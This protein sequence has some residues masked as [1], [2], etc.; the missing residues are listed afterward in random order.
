L[1]ESQN[2]MNDSEFYWIR[3]PQKITFFQISKLHQINAPIMHQ[4]I[5]VCTVYMHVLYYFHIDYIFTL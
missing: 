5:L 3:K 4:I 1:I 2:L